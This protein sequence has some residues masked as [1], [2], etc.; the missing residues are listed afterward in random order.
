MSW[1]QCLLFSTLQARQGLKYV[2]SVM[3]LLLTLS[4]YKEVNVSLR[5]FSVSSK[6]DCVTHTVSFS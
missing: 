3:M 6:S 5:I 2:Q 1:G 4:R